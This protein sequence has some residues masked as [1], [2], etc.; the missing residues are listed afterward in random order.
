MVTV[1]GYISN[2]DRKN[3]IT[4][5]AGAFKV[6]LNETEKVLT[7]VCNDIIRLKEEVKFFTREKDRLNLHIRDLVEEI[8]RLDIH[9]DTLIKAVVA[10]NNKYKT[11][12]WPLYGYPEE[13]KEN[14]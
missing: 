5:S 14:V 6:A 1:T 4:E 3:A 13:N 11:T 9:Y 7:D 2:E 12:I 8:Q 10:E